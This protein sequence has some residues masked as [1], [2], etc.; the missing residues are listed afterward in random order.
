MKASRKKIRASG[1]IEQFILAREFITNA[2]DTANRSPRRL[3]EE[4][5]R[6]TASAAPTYLAWAAFA[7]WCDADA[8]N[9]RTLVEAYKWL[10]EQPS[11]VPGRAS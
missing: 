9:Y 1:G 2:E 6:Q 11:P 5:A 4:V 7:A 10:A 8:S 3:A